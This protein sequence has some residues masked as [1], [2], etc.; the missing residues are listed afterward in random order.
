MERDQNC[1]VLLITYQYSSLSHR[2]FHLIPPN[3]LCF[4]QYFQRI[5]LP[6]VLLLHKNDFAVGALAN[7]RYHFEIFLGDV[8]TRPFLL[9]GDNLL[10]LRI[11]H[12]FFLRLLLGS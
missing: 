1:V 9:F 8:T 6:I 12:L 2:V 5:Q 7:H 10:V 3:N 11:Y 4:L